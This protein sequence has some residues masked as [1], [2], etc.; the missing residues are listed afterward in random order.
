MQQSKAAKVDGSS[1]VQKSTLLQQ[2]GLVAAVSESDGDRPPSEEKEKT[3]S[4]AEG[5]KQEEVEGGADPFLP[6]ERPQQKNK[7]KCWICKSKLELAQRELGTCKCGKFFLMCWMCF[8]VVCPLFIVRVRTW[9]LI[10][11]MYVVSGFKCKPTVSCSCYTNTRMLVR[12]CS[13]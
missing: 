5:E 3:D 1:S 8:L 9:A 7:K 13:T 11:C 10:V 2:L 6:T 12:T 4:Q